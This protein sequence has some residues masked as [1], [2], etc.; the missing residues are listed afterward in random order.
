MTEAVVFHEV[1]KRFGQKL[2]VD[3]LSVV[4]EAGTVVSKYSTTI[5]SLKPGRPEIP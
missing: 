1:S 2:A 3:N 5:S 4:L